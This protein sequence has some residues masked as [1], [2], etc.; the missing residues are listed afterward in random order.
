M[1]SSP[2]AFS[3]GSPGAAYTAQRVN[4]NDPCMMRGARG[5]AT[6]PNSVLVWLPARR[7]RAVV[8]RPEYCDLPEF[9]TRFQGQTVSREM[10]ARNARQV[11][12]RSAP[13]DNVIYIHIARLRKKTDDP[14]EK[15]L[16]H[17]VR[18][19]G[20]MVSEEKS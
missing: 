13:L 2:C 19:G 16:L 14:F 18:G 9:L 5:E 3:L 15:K 12:A 10:L 17:T 7:N 6:V 11:T 1:N 4:R 20:L 8:L